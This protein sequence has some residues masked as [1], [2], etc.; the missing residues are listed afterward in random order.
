VL[1]RFD[2]YSK[3]AMMSVITRNTL[4]GQIRGFAKGSPEKM[5]GL[6]NKNTL[7]SD[8]DDMLKMYTECGFRVIA[9]A[10]KPLD[11][12]ILN[13]S[14]IKRD[15][16]ETNL[17]FLGFIIMQNKLK[18]ITEKVLTDLH[19]AN[20]RTIMATG[21]NILT[22]VHVGRECGIIDKETDLCFGDVVKENGVDTIIWQEV[23][24][25]ESQ[26]KIG[27]GEKQMELEESRHDINAVQLKNPNY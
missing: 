13:Q 3:V 19:K 4:T 7:P 21:D 6:C 9:I 26:T 18:P 22:A 25:K 16:V 11:P 14:D 8:F 5:Y 24:S 2:F 1:K 10:E 27:G 17:N 12:S 23:R 20:I 15:E